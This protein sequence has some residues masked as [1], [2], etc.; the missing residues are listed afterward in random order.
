MCCGSLHKHIFPFSPSLLYSVAGPAGRFSCQWPVL[1]RAGSWA[2]PPSV[3]AACVASSGAACSALVLLPRSCRRST[4]G[5]AAAHCALPRAGRRRCCC[6]LPLLVHGSGLERSL[7]FGGTER[8]Q[9]TCSSKPNSPV[10][11]DPTP[12]ETH[13]TSHPTRQRIL[14][15][16][17]ARR[18]SFCPNSHLRFKCVLLLERLALSCSPARFC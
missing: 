18:S 3:A 14:P 15:L 16:H 2:S 10:R 12:N 6:G 8:T 1:L 11:P 13:A 9:P 17:R 4:L 7:R 5:A